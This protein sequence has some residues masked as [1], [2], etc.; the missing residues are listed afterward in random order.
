MFIRPHT[1]QPR[2]CAT[3]Y[4]HYDVFSQTVCLN[5]AI[6]Q[7]TFICFEAASGTLRVHVHQSTLYC[8][9]LSTFAVKAM[10]Y[11]TQYFTL[12]A[13]TRTSTTHTECIVAFQLQKLLLDCATM[14]RYSALSIFLVPCDIRAVFVIFSYFTSWPASWSSGQS[15][16]LL[17]TRSR[18]RFPALPLE[19]SL[20]G[21][22]PAVT[23]VWVD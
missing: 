2:N 1:I 17:I 7:W 21:K 5:K 11:N 23:M 20:K 8:H 18:V 4:C 10:L 3:T 19:F 6:S 13:V 16:W 14:L 22:I 15:L 12:L 9:R